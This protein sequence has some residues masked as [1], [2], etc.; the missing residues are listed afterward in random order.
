MDDNLKRHVE[1]AKEKGSSIWLTT[2][3]LEKN[4]FALHRS[5]FKDAVSLRYGWLPDALPLR[6]ACDASFSVEHALSC[7]RGAFPTARHNEL[8][9]IT[10]NLLAEVCLDVC[11]E[12]E[13]Q[14][15]DGMV[16][17][18][19]T[20]NIEDNAR[21]DIRARGFWGSRQQ[22]AFFDIKVF[23]PNAPSYKRTSCYIN[24]ERMK[25][26]GYEQR[27]NEIEHGSFTPLIFST[28]GGMGKSATIF[29]KRL[30]S[31]LAN[32]R[33]ESYADTIRWMR[34]QLNFSLL[35]SSILC[36][37]GSRARR[38]PNVP[39]SLLFATRESKI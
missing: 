26:R 4:G 29:Y 33:N 2:L 10:A 30:A 14:P 38:F 34:C 36:I 22:C 32:K 25:K 11:I 19:A 27:I 37:R 3:P 17:R 20:A 9:D 23:N 18:Y 13:L 35:R 31:M 39:D 5:A 16:P 21:S 1:F 15:V 28:S 8:R 6:C 24:H 7:P 12:P